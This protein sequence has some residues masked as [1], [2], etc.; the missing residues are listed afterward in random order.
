MGCSESRIEGKNSSHT[1]STEMEE[2]GDPFKQR[3]FEIFDAIIAD[4]TR[5][6]INL[7]S[8]G[9]EVN[10]RMSSFYYRT[11]MHIACQS[12]S[13]KIIKLL[14]EKGAN[15][16]IEDSYGITPIFL[17]ELKDKKMYF[18]ILRQEENKKTSEGVNNR[19]SIQR[20][21]SVV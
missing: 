18:D 10:Y 19:K 2:S 11:P 17:A 4:D 16:H 12:G 6:I 8:Q 5:A 7:F 21:V 1:L 9:V 13:A 15:L 3:Q 20:K 14:I